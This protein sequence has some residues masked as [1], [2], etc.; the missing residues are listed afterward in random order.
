M[1][2]ERISNDLCSLREGEDRPAIAVRMVF[3]GEG[4]KAGHNFHRVMMKSAAKLSYNQAQAAIDGNP[5]DKAGPLL[6]PILKPPWHA[7]RSLKR[8]PHQRQP[9][10]PDQPP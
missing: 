3:S 8:G 5:A 6:E 4:R 10:K 9:P 2:P 7:Y 1:L